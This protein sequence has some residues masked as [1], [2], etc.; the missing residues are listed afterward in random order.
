[1]H[2]DRQGFIQAST[3]A[4]L[5]RRFLNQLKEFTC[6]GVAVSSLYGCINDGR[7]C[8]DAGV[9]TN[10]A[11]ICDSGRDGQY[12]ESFVSASSSSD[13]STITMGSSHTSTYGSVHC[14]STDPLCSAYLVCCPCGGAFTAVIIPV[15][16]V[17][18]LVLVCF[19]AVLVFLI[20][21]R[22]N[23]SD[24]WEIEYSELE[25]GETLGA[26]GYADLSLPRQLVP[27]PSRAGHDS[28]RLLIRWVASTA[29]MA[30]CTRPCGRARRWP[31]R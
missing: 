28:F 11:C 16:A 4:G 5:Q 18:L 9:C 2:P 3:D 29:A 17:I 12:C 31:S 10:N 30:K 14:E 8:S 6:D 21:R 13:A 25:V 1:L 22:G 27:A 7:L 19:I 20:K 15:A 23:K 24:D 26:G